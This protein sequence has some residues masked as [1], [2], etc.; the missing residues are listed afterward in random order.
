[1]HLKI[2]KIH[3]ENFAEIHLEKFSEIP[4]AAEGC[5]PPQEVEKA[6]HRAE[7]FLVKLKVLTIFLKPIGFPVLKE[8]P[9]EFSDTILCKYE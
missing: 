5:S 7:I 8:F 6:A 4:V 1:M 9:C 2:F 3:L